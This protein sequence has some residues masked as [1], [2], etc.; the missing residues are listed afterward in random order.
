MSG[1]EIS[2]A[3]AYDAVLTIAG[4]S[5]I[6]LGSAKMQTA[7]PANSLVESQRKYAAI[8]MRIYAIRLSVKQEMK[9]GAS[10]KGEG[11]NGKTLSCNEECARLERNRRLALALNIDASMHV[12][13]GDHIPYSDETLGIF[14]KHVKWGQTQ[15]REFRVFASSD[16][17]R[18]LRFK[19]MKPQERS[20]IHALATDFGL[21]SESM[22]PE[23]HRHVMVWKTPRFVSA[24]TKTLAEA[25]RLRTNQRSATA[26][27]N[28][29]DN[30]NTLRKVKASN[31]VGEPFNAFVVDR[32]RFALTVDEL[33]VELAKVI[34]PDLGL[35][36]DINFLPT[37][38]V[39]LGT[40]SNT[41]P[42]Y[43]LEQTL[44]NLK[45]DVVAAIAGKGYGTPQ[46][47]AANGTLSI[48]RRESDTAAGDGW[49]RVAA[50]KAAP[51]TT[52]QS[53]SVGRSSNSFAALTGS[54]KVTFAMK[55]K[56]E[57]AKAKP[58][59]V[60]VD[61]WEMAEQAEEERE[62]V[63]RSAGEEGGVTSYVD[64]PADMALPPSA[65]VSEPDVE[66]EVGASAVNNAVT[67]GVVE[68][69]A[70]T[71]EDESAPPTANAATEA[72]G[73]REPVE[74]QQPASATT[75]WATEGEEAEL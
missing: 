53:A 56:P 64:E 31:D 37:G 6:A 70:K 25:L 51:R 67:E 24:P 28:V 8:L 61:D 19:P 14:G 60:V 1:V 43:D 20:F 44:R 27:A 16:G 5:V 54:N 2:V 21:D 50:K 3:K 72:G 69:S 36:F 11:N 74:V 63:G 29:S 18:R 32:P 30:E 52:L 22:D 35:T 9:C 73:Q 38:E 33:R 49:S 7:Q 4:S 13:G 40:I 66:R 48:L 75:D 45:T 39:L 62:N 65:P 71:E 41:L 68:Q 34:A 26:S 17:E 15:E 42:P 57:K 47:C 55:K 59:A 46:L 23:P 12:E 58:V 10:K